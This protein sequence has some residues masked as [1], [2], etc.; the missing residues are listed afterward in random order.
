[1]KPNGPEIR[2]KSVSRDRHPPKSRDDSVELADVRQPLS[3]SNL[4]FHPQS[5]LSAHIN[6]FVDGVPEKRGNS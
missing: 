1:M 5:P 3:V 4:G 2:N 6:N